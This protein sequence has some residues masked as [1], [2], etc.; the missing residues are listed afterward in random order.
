M[1]LMRLLRMFKLVRSWKSLQTILHKLF[2]SI[3][4]MVPFSFLLILFIY[5][6]SLLGMSF[7]GNDTFIDIN[8]NIVLKNELVERYASED[9]ISVRSSFNNIYFAMNTVFVIIMADGWNFIMY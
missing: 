1:R 2:K 9:L 7:F 6:F 5:I 4:S 8:G 3:E